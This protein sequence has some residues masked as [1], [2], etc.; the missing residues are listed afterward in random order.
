MPSANQQLLFQALP[1]FAPEFDLF[2][3]G[4]KLRARCALP[5]LLAI[6]LGGSDIVHLN[7][8]M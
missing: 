8:M 5:S 6:G 7:F 4:F 3:E 1:A 2:H